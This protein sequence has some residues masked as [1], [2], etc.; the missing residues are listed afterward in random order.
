[1][2]HFVR[3]HEPEETI[4]FFIDGS[5]AQAQKGDT[6]LS[7]LVAAGHTIRPG[8]F[9]ADAHSGFCMMGACQECTAE[10]ADG[11]RVR[12]CATAVEPGMNVLTL[13]PGAIPAGRPVPQGENT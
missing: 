10:L 5:P 13:T 2:P 7:A 8:D 3:L 1:M 12:A 4:G 6:I 11:R 9:A